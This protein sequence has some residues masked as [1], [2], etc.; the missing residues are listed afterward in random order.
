MTATP[1]FP[2]E[3]AM[4]PGEELPLRIFE[5][6]YS[7]M[8]SQCLAGDPVFG[9]VL[10]AAGREVGGGDVRSDVGVLAR[11]VEHADLG[12]GRYR[13]RC[14]LG[15]RIRVTE[16][17]D[18]APYPRAT[19][20]PWPDEAGPS[21]TGADIASVEDTVMAL[22]E[23]IAESRQATLPPREELLG[24]PEPGQE[25]GDRLYAL[26]ARIPLGQADRYAVLAAPGA[27]A[28]LEALR[29]AVET[30]AAMVEFQ[31]SE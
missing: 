14:M 25:A 2:L 26:A 31:L 30:V 28:R 9:V 17:L 21:V 12:E 4:L 3:V 19:T 20:L 22:F 8:V 15:E 5:P 18:D 29:E 10:I 7:A 6:R 27:S 16:W 11:I 13:L 23:R 24:G 1:M